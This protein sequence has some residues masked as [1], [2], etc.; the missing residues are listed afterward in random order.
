MNELPDPPGP[1]APGSPRCRRSVALRARGG[2]PS[3]GHRTGGGRQR[4]NDRRRDRR[5]ARAFRRQIACAPARPC[6]DDRDL[7]ARVAR[8]D[9]RGGRSA[10]CRRCAGRHA[11]RDPHRDRCQSNQSRR[12]GAGRAPDPGAA[13]TAL[14]E[15]GALG[16]NRVFALSAALAA[17]DEI[18]ID[19][20]PS[21]LA[22]CSPVTS[23][24]LA[25]PPPRSPS[26]PRTRRTCAFSSAVR[27]PRPASTCCANRGRALG[28]AVGAGSDHATRGARHVHRGPSP[29]G[30]RPA[31]GR[32]AGRAAQREVAAQLFAATR[33]ASFARCSASRWRSS[34]RI[35]RTMHRAAAS[36]GC[37]SPRRCLLRMRRAFAVALS[38]RARRRRRDDAV[39]PFGRLSRRGCPHRRWRARR[40]RSGD[41]R[42]G[43]SPDT[44]P[45]TP[46]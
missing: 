18:D 22:A 13:V 16:G 25:L 7:S 46:S 6:A 15:H 9:S 19:K 17:A 43:C 12:D 24:S 35:A 4:C 41:G 2:K 23:T 8:A 38:R 42:A 26:A 1:R 21:L 39:R 14:R 45:A 37:L 31:G 33:C 34:A 5:A 10:G 20:L 44:M 27:L 30:G 3:C 36:S 11:V 29:R 32:C 40:P 28:P